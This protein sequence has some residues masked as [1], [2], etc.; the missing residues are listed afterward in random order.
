MSFLHQSLFIFK[1]FQGSVT[2]SQ[3]WN[4]LQETG[5]ISTGTKIEDQKHPRKSILE[6]KLSELQGKKW[7]KELDMYPDLIRAIRDGLYDKDKDGILVVDTHKR[8]DIHVD[9]S[10]AEHDDARL[11]FSLHYFLEFKLPGVEPRTTSHC[12]QM[13]DYFK[14][15]QEKQPRRSHFIGILSNYSTTWV[16]VALFGPEGPKIDEYQCSSLADAII[17]AENSC[18]SKLQTKIP[19]LDPALDLKFPVIAL[20]KHYFLFTVNK[21]IDLPDNRATRTSRRQIVKNTGIDTGTPN[22]SPRWF[23]PVRYKNGRQ[24]GQF[25]LKISHDKTSMEKEIMILQELRDT[26]CKHIPELVWTRGIQE[27]GI[28][29]LGEPVL[30]GESAVISCEIVHGMIKGLKHLHNLGIIHRD[31][32]LSNLILERLQNKVNVVIIDYETAIKTEGGQVKYSGGYICWPRRLLLSKEESYIPEPSDDLF[33][34]ILVVL[35]LLFPCRFDE[36]NASK[37]QEAGDDQNSERGR[38]LKMWRDIESSKLWGQFYDA[39]RDKNY[40]ELLD[41]SQVFSHV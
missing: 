36:F 7:T 4:R 20:G 32:R 14:T 8:H 41:I 15:V 24:K 6:S 25:V 16:Y 17:F 30:P 37:I 19:L 3:A 22:C 34:C 26:Q 28:L 33:A 29:P 5:K 13:L 27:L 38:V 18:H 31:I 1:P 21:R 39:A 23:S 10:V 12:G 35:H 9:V 40:D 11:P 2:R